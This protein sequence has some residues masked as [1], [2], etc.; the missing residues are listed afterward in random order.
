MRRIVSVALIVALVTTTAP[1]VPAQHAGAIQIENAWA[2][3][4]PAMAHG[5]SA[6]HGTGGSAAPAHGGGGNGAVY[7]TI[8]NRGAEPDALVGATSDAATTVE[9]HETVQ[10]G[11]VMKMRPRSKFEVAAGGRLEMKPGGHHIMLLGL[12]RD[13]EPGGTVSV[14]ITFE[15]AGR[16]TVDAPV[17]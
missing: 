2:R 14:T 5:Q 4:A 12:R 6:G 10:E 17:R 13:L 7:V 15:R 3:R 1:A 16:M 8:T 11:T 9:L